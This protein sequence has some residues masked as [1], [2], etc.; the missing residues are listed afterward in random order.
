MLAALF[1]APCALGGV[2]PWALWG[3]WALAGLALG[4]ALAAAFLEGRRLPGSLAGAAL[5][6]MALMVAAQCLPLPP[7]LLARL[8]PAADD[9]FRFTL[10]PNHLYPAWRPL[11]LDPPATA[12]ELGKALSYLALFLAASQVCREEAARRRLTA[13]LG[14][15]GAALA[16]LAFVHQLFGM[17]TLLGFA[18]LPRPGLVSPFV[19]RNNL[20]SV[21]ELGALVQLGLAVRTRDARVASFWGLCFLFTGA[22]VLLSGSRAGAVS[23]LAAGLVFAAL[24]GVKGRGSAL[25]HR[26]ALGLCFLTGVLAVAVFLNGDALLA[27]LDSLQAIPAT[28]AL[29]QIWPTVVPMVR[30]HWLTGIGRGAFEAAFPHVQQGFAAN[31][32]T[33]PENVILQLT[34]E[35]G[36]VGGLGLLVVLAGAWTYVARRGDL[37][38]AEGGL[39]AALFAVGLHEFADFGL[40]LTGV[41][42]PALVALAVAVTQPGARGRLPRWAGA[43]A[44]AALAVLGA[45]GLRQSRHRLSRDRAAL[46]AALHGGHTLDSVT[47]LAWQTLKRHPA[48]Y[49]V[50]LDAALAAARTHPPDPQRALFWAGRAMYLAPISPW[51]HRL[52]AE[53]L[54]LLGKPDQALDEE[55]LA[56]PTFAGDPSFQLDLRRFVKSPKDFADLAAPT[57]DGVKQVLALTAFD[58]A[59]S[60][61]AGD[62]ALSRVGLEVPELLLRLSA[63]AS[64]QGLHDR[65]LA[66]AQRA[67]RAAPDDAAAFNR[68][69]AEQ[70][71]LGD[72]VEAEA[73]LR[74]GLRQSPG[75]LG[76]SEALANILARRKAFDEAHRLLTQVVTPNPRQRAGALRTDAQIWRM[77]GVDT[78]AVAAMRDAAALSPADPNGQYALAQLLLSLGRTR[79]A[80]AAIDRGLGIDHGPSRTQKTAWRAKV[81]AQAEAEDR[82]RLLR[83]LDAHLNAPPTPGSSDGDDG[84]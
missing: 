5:G 40:E 53:S 25:R 41:A 1:F 36:A 71:A 13:A 58:P 28:H 43:T 31:T 79:E 61:A 19:N 51:A 83:Q 78:R 17:T 9:L 70:A 39:L 64:A 73:T 77:Q 84:R 47:A 2:A 33:H 56:L 57:P 44:L 65:A 37:S 6:A 81:S 82:A 68:L 60:L 74:D 49:V 7:A 14:L 30:A 59:L 21:L 63:L 42:V 35:L 18:E 75:E 4:G 48:D 69:A 52:A 26:V 45:W 22:A 72:P 11:S 29:P 54:F 24:V 38:P 15:L 80:L 34:S 66:Y 12:V 67:L 50:A 46:T 16:G 8:A 27:Q 10:G 55:R 32:F 3:V 23:F 76:L 62:L 20:A